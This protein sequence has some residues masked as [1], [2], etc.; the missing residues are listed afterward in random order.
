M[1]VV[2]VV[3]RSPMAV[4]VG[5]ERLPQDVL[6]LFTIR[7]AAAIPRQLNPL[8]HRGD[9]EDF[10]VVLSSPNEL[11]HICEGTASIEPAMSERG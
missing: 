1:V 5:V 9:L 8:P 7:V 10:P 3:F 2:V 6:V 4:T 11:Y